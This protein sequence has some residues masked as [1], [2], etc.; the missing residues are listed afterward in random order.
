MTLEDELILELDELTATLDALVVAVELFTG[1][2]LDEPPPPPPQ[3]D[4]VKKHI[5][6][7]KENVSFNGKFFIKAP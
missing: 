1:L 4:K 6:K 5:T 7:N 2:L 3:A